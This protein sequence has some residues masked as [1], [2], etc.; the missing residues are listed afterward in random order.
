MEVLFAKEHGDTENVTD[1]SPLPL[2]VP[3][4]STRRGGD[5]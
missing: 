2:M 1:G 5:L 3:G 4:P